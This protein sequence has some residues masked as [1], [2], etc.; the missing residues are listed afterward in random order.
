MPKSRYFFGRHWRAAA[1]ESDPLT[2]MARII[3]ISDNPAASSTT[4]SHHRTLLH[5]VTR[6][7]LRSYTD[8]RENDTPKMIDELDKLEVTG[9]D[10]AFLLNRRIAAWSFAVGSTT[11]MS[12]NAG[13]FPESIENA[14][15]ERI[16]AG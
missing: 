4:A 12:P 7:P 3:S 5:E 8:T 14:A 9:S 16:P 10:R 15:Q 6:R 13:L 11:S 2:K 1:F